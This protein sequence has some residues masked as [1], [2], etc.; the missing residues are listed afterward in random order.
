M[1]HQGNEDNVISS[2]GTSAAS[3]DANAPSDQ[4]KQKPGYYS[5][6]QLKSEHP[7]KS[8]TSKARI[9]IFILF[10][11]TFA[12]LSATVLRQPIMD[13]ERWLKRQGL[14]GLVVYGIVS[15]AFLMI[16]G[17]ANLIDLI[18]GFVY[19]SRQGLAMA[20]LVKLLATICAYLAGRYLFRDLLVTYFFKEY[21]WLAAMVRLVEERP[22]QS[23]VLIRLA[24]IPA[25]VKSYGLGAIEDPPIPFFSC[26]I[27]IMAPLSWILTDLG[28]KLQDPK[29]IFKAQSEGSQILEIVGITCIFLVLVCGAWFGRKYVREIKAE[30]EAE[31]SAVQSV[32]AGCADVES[33]QEDGNTPPEAE[34]E[35][36]FNTKDLAT[37]SIAASTPAVA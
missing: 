12:V 32:A 5:F 13:S 25:A 1:D 11:V 7:T 27:V 17:S 10:L 24:A 14:N 2:N 4:I 29:D 15:W 36:L 16:G 23:N 26:A 22:W 19:G 33:A 37:S 31:M 35:I 30:K 18:S 8:W 9:W 28:A 3:D 6:P 21:V 34:E 20:Y